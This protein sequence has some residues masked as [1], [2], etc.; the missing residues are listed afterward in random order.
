MTRERPK[1]AKLFDTFLDW[2][3]G[4]SKLTFLGPEEYITKLAARLSEDGFKVQRALTIELRRIEI[5]AVRPATRMGGFRDAVLVS[6]LQD[7]TIGS[8]EE[9]TKF[10]MTYCVD[11][12]SDL[13]L[14]S[15]D[16]LNVFAVI[17]SNN[18]SDET[19]QAIEVTRPGG[20]SVHG[21]IEFAILA[22]VEERRLYSYSKTPIRAGL[23]FKMLRDF[24]QRSIGFEG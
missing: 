15:G 14:G 1:I 19:K 21:R 11:H 24:A 9:F 7:A 13:E 5:F 16:N 18:F 3:S 12:R 23:R 4:E 6:M 10:A 2:K 22:S 20:S 8:I 17:V